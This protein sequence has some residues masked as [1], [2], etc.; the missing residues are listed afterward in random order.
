MTVYTR[1]IATAQR[2]L[3]RYGG[4][5]GSY[6][7]LGEDSERYEIDIYA[8]SG[9]ATVVRTISAT[10]ESVA[11]SAADQTT[12]FGSVQA[13][14]YAR[15]YQLSVAVGRGHYLQETA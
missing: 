4:A 9:Y 3:T 14:V 13:T 15:V 2:L 1:P 7:P 11:Y 5:G 10:S 6:T 12:D 8:T